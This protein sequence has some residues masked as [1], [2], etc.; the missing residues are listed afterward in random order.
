VC[1]ENESNERCDKKTEKIKCVLETAEWM[2]NE[3]IV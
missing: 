1:K 2:E 3:N